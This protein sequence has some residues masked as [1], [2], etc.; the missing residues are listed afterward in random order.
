MKIKELLEG[1][2][3]FTENVDKALLKELAGKGQ[4]PTA[5]VVSCSDSRVPV[6]VIF[7]QLKPG[8]LFVIRVAGN[9]VSDTSVKGS[10][11]YA[12]NH[13]KVPYV[14]VL[15]HT[16]CGAVK[17]CLAG[18]NEGELGRLVR[19]MKLASRDLN[20]AVIENVNLQVKRVMKM[21]CVK[22]AIE[23]DNLEVYGMLYELATGLV[24]GLSKNDIALPS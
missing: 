13:L 7:N 19:H 10:I 21:A 22:S 23:K 14:I 15:G 9:V 3:S 18:A 20:E 8:V 2:W 17:A 5:A 11:E 24:A 16:D 6:E 4:K 1:N 12:V